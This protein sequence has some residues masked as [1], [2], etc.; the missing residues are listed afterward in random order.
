MDDK[1]DDTSRVK[2]EREPEP[3]GNRRIVRRIEITVERESTTVIL[4]RKDAPAGPAE[5]GGN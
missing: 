5:D 3:A 4:R 2:A 1:T